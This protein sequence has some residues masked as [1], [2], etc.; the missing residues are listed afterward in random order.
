[1]STGSLGTSSIQL[2]IS[3]SFCR[4]AR[5]NASEKG[6]NATDGNVPVPD[7]TPALIEDGTASCSSRPLWI[8]MIA[9]TSASTT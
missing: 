7:D 4:V 2:R 6:K 1:M 9:K 8:P 5:P 3:A